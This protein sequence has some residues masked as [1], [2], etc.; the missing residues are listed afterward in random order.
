MTKQN[1]SDT[2]QTDLAVELE[3]V[4]EVADY[5]KGRIDRALEYLAIT[6]D[7]DNLD[8]GDLF[9]AIWHARAALNGIE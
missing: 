7:L 9:L 6:D 4:Q 8:K 5:A 3:R 2:N 1:S